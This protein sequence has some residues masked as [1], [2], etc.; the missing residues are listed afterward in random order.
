MGRFRG[1][2]QDSLSFK[3]QRWTSAFLEAT[4][5]WPEGATSI[6]QR[7]R[8]ISIGKTRVTTKSVSSASG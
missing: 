6:S 5:S 3:I 1:R 2:S 7:R 4:C 8:P